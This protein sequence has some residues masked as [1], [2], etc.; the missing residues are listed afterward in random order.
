MSTYQ[1]VAAPAACRPLSR[2][3]GVTVAFPSVAYRQ[4]PVPRASNPAAASTEAVPRGSGEVQEWRQLR[5]VVGGILASIEVV[6]TK[7]GTS[8]KRGDAD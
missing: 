3:P 7:A 6:P 4:V 2:V 8:V 5:D 1:S